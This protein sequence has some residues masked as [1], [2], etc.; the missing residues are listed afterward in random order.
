MHT[1]I[2]ADDHELVREALARHAEE[3]S[4][5]KVLAAVSS[6][7]DALRACRLH[8]P[9][10]LVLDAGMPG[11]D[12]LAAIL[13]IR[14]ASPTTRIVV[15]SGSCRDD[16][17]ELAVRHGAI[18]YL[19]KSEPTAHIFAALERARQGHRVYSPAAAARLA[20]NVEGKPSSR[21][22]TSRLSRLTPRELEVLRAIARGLS[23][24]DMARCMSISK[25]TV[26]RHVSRLM[27]AIAIRDRAAIVRF[28]FE[29]GLS[30]S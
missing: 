12:P 3:R 30:C 28:A 19:L 22:E 26:E 4:G 6:A 15:L 14:Y 16:S 2:I 27:D 21:P 29:H 13:D 1:M 20:A 17:I 10:L 25:R 8:Q 24:D 18:G 11:R 7:E 5:W 9:E 23:N